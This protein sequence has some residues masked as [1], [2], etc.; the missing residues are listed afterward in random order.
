MLYHRNLISHSRKEHPDRDHQLSNQ[1]G[2]VELKRWQSRDGDSRSFEYPAS[3]ENH[4]ASVGKKSRPIKQKAQQPPSSDQKQREDMEALDVFL[5]EPELMMFGGR[6]T[7]GTDL[8][9]FVR[10]EHFKQD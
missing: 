5:S 1:V 4:F 2:E 7:S 10:E 6:L 3:N 8:G 9:D